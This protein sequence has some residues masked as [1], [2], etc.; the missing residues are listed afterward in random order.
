[1]LL[2]AEAKINLFNLISISTLLLYVG[3]NYRSIIRGDTYHNIA[4]CKHFHRSI[5][6]YELFNIQEQC[7]NDIRFRFLEPSDTL[8]GQM[9]VRENS[10]RFLPQ[11]NTWHMRC[12]SYKSTFS[13]FEFYLLIFL[14]IIL[15]HNSSPI[16]IFDLNAKFT[17]GRLFCN[18]TVYGL[19]RCLKLLPIS[20]ATKIAS[21]FRN[22]LHFY[23]FSEY[24]IL[25]NM[26][27]L[28]RN[29]F[30]HFKIFRSRLSYYSS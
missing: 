6:R 15:T 16:N 18:K 21:F 7:K 28:K 23:V 27:I 8:Q 17:F 29:N 13:S 25:T 26:T 2:S 10:G 22:P 30:Y 4:K 14:K 9:C 20:M 3:R 1:M 19:M 5:L 12:S 11:K 24:L